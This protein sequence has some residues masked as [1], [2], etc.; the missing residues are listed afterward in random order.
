M[1]FRSPKAAY[2]F[3]KRTWASQAV[4][5]TDEGLNGLDLHV[6]N[7][8]GEPLAATVELECL[9]D[10]RTRSAH[11]LANINLPPFSANTL[12]GDAL[13]GQ[14]TD[15]VHAYRFGPPKHDVVIARLRHTVTGNVLHEDVFFPG[16]MDLPLQLGAKVEFTTLAEA[17]ERITLT[18]QSDTFLQG[19][20]FVCPAYQPD[21]NHFHLAPGVPKTVRFHAKTRQDVN[22]KAHVTAV[23][24]R[25]TWTV[26]CARG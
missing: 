14:F 21:D 22:F 17:P 16:G 8:T 20:S 2:W 6:I 11:G 24:V 25:E 18:L 13:L 10:G 9:Q 7:E 12:Q 19:V 1:L 23:N 3:L 15:L 5:M 26:R 4:L